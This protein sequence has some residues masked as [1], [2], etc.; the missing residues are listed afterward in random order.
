MDVEIPD[1]LTFVAQ[2]IMFECSMLSEQDQ[3]SSSSS[4]RPS[5]RDSLQINLLNATEPPKEALL[6]TTVLST[7]LTPTFMALQ[8]ITQSMAPKGNRGAKKSRAGRPRKSEATWKGSIPDYKPDGL[9]CDCAL[10][11]QHLK[12]IHKRKCD[13]ASADHK[14]ELKAERERY[15]LLENIHIAFVR[16]FNK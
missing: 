7:W 16:Q 14:K 15:K 4:S 10:K 11:M 1:Y 6:S 8:P 12:R 2:E 9:F 13:R 5:V 3:N